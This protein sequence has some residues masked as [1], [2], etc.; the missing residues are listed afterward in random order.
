M[1]VTFTEKLQELLAARVAP[2]RLTEPEP[3]AAVIV[4]PPQEPVRPL[5]VATT[6]PEGRVSV[7]AT[8]VRAVP[9]L[10]LV[11]VNVRLVVTFTLMLAAPKA[12]VI[13]GGAITVM[14]AVLLVAPGPLCVDEIG[15]VVF[16]LAPAVVPCTFTEIVQEPLAARV[17]PAR[18]T[19]DGDGAGG[20]PLVWLQISRDAGRRFGP[21]NA[22]SKGQHDGPSRSR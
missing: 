19:G 8:P 5:G 4:P 6:K 14:L 17:P 20:T 12:L 16:A 15:P 10:G 1:L 22:T 7:N 13:D 11:I 9:V 3:A 18:L 21:G 2:V